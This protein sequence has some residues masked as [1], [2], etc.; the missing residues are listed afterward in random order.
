MKYKETLY[1]CDE[2]VSEHTALNCTFR[3]YV[4]RRT[5]KIST[6]NLIII[7][8]FTVVGLENEEVENSV[9]VGLVNM[10]VLKTTCDTTHRQNKKL[11]TPLVRPVL[12]QRRANTSS[13]PTC[14]VTELY[15]GDLQITSSV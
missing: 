9:F 13:Q 7:I 10:Y 8:R 11:I 2:F 4:Y 6:F 12:L 14:V 3:L 1:Q 5:E 15:Y